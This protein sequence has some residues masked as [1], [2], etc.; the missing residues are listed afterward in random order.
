MWSFL[1]G[2]AI[3]RSQEIQ[4]LLQYFVPPD[5]KPL[6]KQS[7]SFRL[8]IVNVGKEVFFTQAVDYSQPG[9]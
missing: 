5:K 3:V 1:L 4:S 9:K 2:P 8:C 7:Q 6:G